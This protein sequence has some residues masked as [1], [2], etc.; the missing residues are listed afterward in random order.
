MKLTKREAIKWL[1][2]HLEPNLQ[3]SG[4]H[5]YR[6]NPNSCLLCKTEQDMLMRVKKVLGV[7]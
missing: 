2:R 7:G 3:R 1:I 4:C 6:N 5:S